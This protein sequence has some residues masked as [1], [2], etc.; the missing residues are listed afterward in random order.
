VPAPRRHHQQPTKQRG[1]PGQDLQPESASV[2]RPGL[3]WRVR[4]AEIGA[5]K[6]DDAAPDAKQGHEEP[7][8][9]PVG[10]TYPHAPEHCYHFPFGSTALVAFDPRR[11][12]QG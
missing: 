12:P 6:R 1:G 4:V 11:K 10:A 5:D 3:V 9:D 2:V 7:A 8:E